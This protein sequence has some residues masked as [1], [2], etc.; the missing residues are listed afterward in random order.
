VLG[1]RKTDGGC[2][3]VQRRGKM[4]RLPAVGLAAATFLVV[5]PTWSQQQPSGNPGDPKLAVASVRLENGYRASKI[6]GAAVYNEQ[7]QQVGEISDLSR[8][9]QVAMAIVS[10]GGFLGVGAK[11]VSVSFDKLQIGDG[12]KVVMPGGS[13]EELSE[14]PDVNF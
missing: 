10:V 3:K 13:K 6:I 1:R 2:R 8:Q 4:L 7:N 9:N 5:S 12:N 11:L 14:M